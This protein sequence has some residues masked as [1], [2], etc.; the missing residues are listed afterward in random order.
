MSELTFV[1]GGASSGKS[2]VA[3]RLVAAAGPRWTYLATLAPD[4]SDPEMSARIRRHQ[5]R[6]AGAVATVVSPELDLADVPPDAPLLIDSLTTHLSH[7]LLRDEEPLLAAY[8]ADGPT[9]L[10]PWLA[11]TE[12]LIAAACERTAPTVVVSDE[13][14]MAVVPIAALT[15]AFRDLVGLANR[16][17]SAAADRALL[18]VAGRAIPLP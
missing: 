4:A 6:R 2:E 9:G 15:R 5:T 11:P 14:G 3:E 1:L 18:V 7:V 13:L 10:A 16:R 12:G 17:V 8:R